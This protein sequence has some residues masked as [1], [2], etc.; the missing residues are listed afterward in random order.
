MILFSIFLCFLNCFVIRI[1][2]GAQ[3]GKW[4]TVFILMET[5]KMEMKMG[6]VDLRRLGNRLKRWTFLIGREVKQFSYT[7]FKKPILLKK[8][9]HDWQSEWGIWF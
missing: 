7:L 6:S 1:T 2:R 4:P 3:V 9:L 5:L 8:R